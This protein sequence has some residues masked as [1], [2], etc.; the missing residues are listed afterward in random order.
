MKKASELVKNLGKKAEETQKKKDY[1]RAS[2]WPKCSKAGCPLWSTI[3][4]DVPTCG[5]H[6]R[7]NG[8]QADS[9]TEAVK[10]HVN[11]INKYKEMCRWDVRQWREKAPQIMGWPVLPAT[12]EEMD[13]PTLYLQRLHAWINSS[14]KKRAEEIYQGK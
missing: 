12:Q 8:L 10:E 7:T 3:K 6:H 5:H 11:Y 4:D 1:S 2:E 14:I 13:L 9:I